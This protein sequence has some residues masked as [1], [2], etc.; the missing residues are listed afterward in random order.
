MKLHSKHRAGAAVLEG[1]LAVPLLA[2]LAFATF[3]FGQTI[4]FERVVVAAAEEAAREVAKGATPNQ[5]ADTVQ[6]MFRPYGL[7]VGPASGVR[8]DIQQ[9][10]RP[11][12]PVGDLRLPPPKR[13]DFETPPRGS[14]LPSEVRVTVQVSY[15]ASGI[16]DILGRL[17]T[18]F[19]RRR[20]TATAIAQRQS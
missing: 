14:L 16:P 15:E 8:I 10:A 7:R 6:R 20:F 4:A 5:I 9:T 1:L 2:L 12:L 13:V 18:D 19:I 17:G 11:P 3:Q